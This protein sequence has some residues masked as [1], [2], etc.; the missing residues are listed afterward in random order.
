MSAPSDPNAELN[1]LRDQIIGL[2]SRS[3]RK[4]YYP[5]L[6]QQIEELQRAKTALEEKSDSLQRT[7]NELEAARQRAEES[8]QRFRTLFEEITDGIVAADPQTQQFVKVNQAFC[9]MLGYSEAE[10]LQ[11]HIPDIHPPEAL[12]RLMEEVAKLDYGVSVLIKDLPFKRKDGSIFYTEI[13]ATTIDLD[14]R[15]CS[16]GVCRDITERKQAEEALIHEQEFGR[17]LVEN[18]VA[19]VIACNANFEL[20]LFNRTAR[21]WHGVDATTVPP[22]Q[23]AEFYHLFCAD[24]VT[25][26]SVDDIPLTRGFRGEILHNEPMVIRAKDQPPRHVLANSAPFFDQQGRKL[27]AVAVMHDITQRKEAEEALKREQVFTNAVMDSVPGLLY[28]YDA[29]GNLIRWNKQHE[30]ITGYSPEELSRMHLLDWY[31]G[32]EE[33]TALI[34]RL[35]EQC[36]A[37]GYAEADANLQT[38]SGAKIRFHLT[39]VHLEIEGKEYFAGI[40]IDITDRE[41]AEQALIQSE[42]KYRE[43]VENANSIILRWTPDGIITYLNEFGLT[44]FGYSE[45][46]IE[47]RRVT[48]TIVPATESTGRAL[49][50]LISDIRANPKEFEHNINE[51]MR[52]NGERVWIAW[53]NK[54]VLDNEGRVTEILSIGSDVTERIRGEEALK[55]AKEEA[56]AANRAKDQFIAVLS[57]E[58]RTPLTPVLTAIALL[59]SHEEASDEVRE[60]MEIIRRNVE[61][62]AKLIDDL[63]DV[64]RISRGI[65]EL[66]PE[67]VD[68]HASLIKT[69]EICRSDIAAKGI[70]MTLSLE[71]RDHYVWADSAR[72]QQV[73]W[74]LL[75]NAVKFTPGEGRISIVTSNT[76]QRI[77]IE[78]TDTGIGI[79]PQVLPRIFNAFEQGEQTKT[80]RFG[81]LGLGLNIAKT[82]VELHHGHLTA[83][84]EGQNKGSVFTVELDTIIATAPGQTAAAVA[85]PPQQEGQRKILLVEDHAD[86]QRILSRLFQKWGYSVTSTHCVAKALDLA[87]HEPFDLLVSDIGLPDGSGLD[88]MRETKDRYGLHGIALSGFGTD[89]DRRQS[90]AA[91][92]DEHLTKPVG[93]E[94]LRAAVERI[95]SLER[96]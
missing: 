40:G 82:V 67:A 89:D 37:E 61:L 48:G 26:M 24:G 16:L 62:E 76:D 6:Q 8:E 35:V 96:P 38:K 88:I 39:A 68:V 56:E 64:T 49:F 28:L 50:P 86:T 73:F 14:N 75:K 4:S 11:L 32:S 91:G 72:L 74:N 80:R 90:R 20:T 27:G 54:V 36:L 57:H 77:K 81:G 12:L 43:L 3:I 66:H 70:A 83:A 52:R 33:D 59:Q 53:T 65:V 29:A 9:Q 79:D 60:E 41:R 55:K 21:E 58:L 46:E 2:G 44:F 25:P 15:R 47:G 87:A 42:R 69:L 92:F 23:W 34:A 31:R 17:A 22:E 51:N 95:L 85:A 45:E 71:A 5:Q 63:L 84:S 18:I 94:S 10:L 78:F 19:A 7:L 30:K 93:I 1:E 13:N